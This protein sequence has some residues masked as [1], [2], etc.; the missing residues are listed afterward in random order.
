MIR[1]EEVRVVGPDLELICQGKMKVDGRSRFVFLLTDKV[2][3]TK[4]AGATYRI[5]AVVSLQW[6]VLNNQV[7]NDGNGVG[8]FTVDR[9]GTSVSF[10]YEKKDTQINWLQAFDDVLSHLNEEVMGHSIGRLVAMEDPTYS[11]SSPSSITLSSSGGVKRGKSK[12]P[13]KACPFIITACVSFLTRF[14]TL[15]GLFRVPGRRAHIKSLR[16]RFNQ[17]GRFVEVSCAEPHDVAALLM[18][19]LSSLPE[20]LLHV[21]SASLL[22]FHQ[23]SSP[24]S[25]SI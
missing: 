24:C 20:P 23:R 19:F 6:A 17:L 8:S 15:P 16:K 12:E 5:T 25:G 18:E 21:R 13:P 7:E 10:A 4:Q 2:I 11:R 1:R 3:V 14:V 22:R 9:S